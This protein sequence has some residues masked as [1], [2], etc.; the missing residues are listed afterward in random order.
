MA[1]FSAD[2]AP[3]VTSVRTNITANVSQ[4][5]FDA[6]VMLVF[7]IGRSGFAGSSVV[8]LVND[9]AAKTDYTDLEAAWK[10]WNKS[11]GKVMKGLDNRR[12]CEWNVYSK[13]VYAKW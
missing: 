12:Q 4:Q 7:N 8:K 1:L 6:L 5:E 3:F 2:L 10:S 9:P 11:Q 13:G